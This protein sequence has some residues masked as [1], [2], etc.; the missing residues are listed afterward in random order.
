MVVE[1]E[2]SAGGNI[3][4][5]KHSVLSL[6]SIQIQACV[7]DWIKAQSKQQE[8]DQDAPYDFFNDDQH[9]PTAGTDGND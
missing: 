1:Q 6:E 4:D 8:I 2:F 3:L 5:A 7:D 9:T